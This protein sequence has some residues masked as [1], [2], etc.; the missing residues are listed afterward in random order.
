[1]KKI[2]F[3]LL[4]LFLI[5]NIIA[6]SGAGGAV[7]YSYQYL[8]K[9]RQDAYTEVYKYRYKIAEGEWQDI[10]IY[11]YPDWSTA[12]EVGDDTIP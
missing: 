11:R 6:C 12:I 1:M 9:V 8:D 4:A 3:S 10:D 5:L 2:A 7:D